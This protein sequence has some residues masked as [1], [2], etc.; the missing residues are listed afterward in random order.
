LATQ[1]APAAEIAW[2]ELHN[3]IIRAQATVAEAYGKGLTIDFHGQN[4][5]EDWI[6]LGFG[7]EGATL[8]E[9]PFGAG[10]EWPPATANQRSTICGLWQRQSHSNTSLN[11]DELL[12]GP[13]SFGSLLLDELGA[14]EFDQT[15]LATTRVVPSP[16]NKGPAGSV[17]YYQGG[18]IT[19]AAA[20]GA[21]ALAEDS[22]GK[23]NDELRPSPYMLDGIQL[24]LP[25]NPS[26]QYPLGI[27]FSCSCQNHSTVFLN[28]GTTVLILGK[29]ATHGRQ[30]LR[31][32]RHHQPTPNSSCCCRMHHRV[33]ALG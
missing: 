3:F 28:A 23:L 26:K 25:Q 21:G 19:Q 5:S 30:H 11:F 13:T 8:D 17:N 2:T 10:A 20:K 7:I 1:S 4:H 15:D 33:K 31:R 16:K 14:T 24:E 27:I 12:R 22:Q 29:L 6:E 32:L 18:F 9:Q